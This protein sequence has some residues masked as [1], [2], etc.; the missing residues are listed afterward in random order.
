MRVSVV[1]PTLNS[2]TIGR[3]LT[4]LLGQRG[5]PPDEVIVV[6]RDEAGLIGPCAGLVW[7][8]TGRAVP[9]AMARNL[10]AAHAHGDILCFMDADCEPDPAWLATLVALFADPGR[11]IVGGGVAFDD[12]N[13]W[14]MADNIATFYPYLATAHAGPRDQLPSLNL[15]VRRATWLAVGP[16]DE[17]YP[18]PAAEDSDWC[19]RARR[20]GYGLDF[21]P[22]AAVWHRP[23]RATPGAL[24]RHAVRFGVFSTKV[25]PRH[26]DLWRQ[27]WVFR[28][29]L[30]LLAAA[31]A[32]AAAVTARAFLGNR[33][34]WPYLH[35][36]PAVYL[37]KLGWCWG[38]AHTLRTGPAVA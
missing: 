7:L 15:A 34:L 36:F 11:T 33:G 6:G 24:W 16:F 9:P 23:A 21:A 37:A 1:I 5:G 8:D 10:G 20:L 27:P 26:H 18:F 38:A 28:H 12:H 22:T 19:L 30:L 17:R 4:A 32:L 13:Y 29:W 31:P 2:P 25:D 14:T 35:A 3:T